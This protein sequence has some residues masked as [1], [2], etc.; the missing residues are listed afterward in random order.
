MVKNAQGNLTP[1]SLNQMLTHCPVLAAKVASQQVECLS[2]QPVKD[3]TDVNPEDWLS[4]RN[5]ILGHQSSHENVL[6]LH[7][8][9]TMAYTSSALSFLM[10]GISKNIV[11]TGSQLPVWEDNSDGNTNITDSLQV[12]DQLALRQITGQTLLCFGGKTFKGNR[13]SKF[14]TSSFDA[15]LGSEFV[16]TDNQGSSVY[17]HVFEDVEKIETD[18]VLVKMHPGIQL[19]SQ[20]NY[21]LANPPKGILLESFGSGNIPANNSFRNGL[22]KLISKGVIVLNISQCLNGYV[23]MEKYESGL[24]LLNIGV[25]NGKNMS[26]EAAITKLM[27]VLSIS[28]YNKPEILTSTIAGEM[29]TA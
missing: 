1:F 14:S 21:L 10:L 9:D 23:S 6:I 11:F 28:G 24:Q 26:S 17:N 5:L 12:L 16:F 4:L 3:S 25:V 18:V 8:T 2:L 13:V 15:F 7:G 19:E 29:T 22:K 20:M 27:V